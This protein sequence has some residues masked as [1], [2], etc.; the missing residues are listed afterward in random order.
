MFS[1]SL[2]SGE[3]PELERL[4]KEIGARGYRIIGP[5]LE[6][7]VIRLGEL[8]SFD[9]I[10]Y[11]VGDVQKPGYYRIQVNGGRFRSPLDSPKRILY[12]PEL[13][14]FKVT[15]D[16]KLEYPEYR[17][18]ATALFGIKPC[19]LA[20]IRIMDRVQGE[21]GDEY[22]LKMREKLLIVVENCVEPGE[23][24]FCAT[25]GTGPAA[26]TGFD[27]AY[28]RLDDSTILF[29]P[30]SDLGVDLLGELNLEPAT[31]DQIDAF[32]E[33]L[34]KASE[35]ARAGFRLEN[36]PDILELNL[37]SKAYQEIAE[38]CLGCANCNMVCP[39][40]FCFDV[41]DEP[42]LDGS[43]R[44][45]RIW[46]GCHSYSYAQVAGGNFRKD[47]WARYRHW[48]LHK[49]VYWLRQFGSFGCVGCGRCITWCP[50]GID[51][52]EVISKVV[53]EVEERC[54]R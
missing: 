13:T 6:D 41:I 1:G 9:E 4:F 34:L 33:A 38:R 3:L 10:P 18:E 21:L 25:M 47:L 50:A 11:G 7:G 54:K 24:C 48:I 35:K 52:R 49:F 22:F 5:K 17:F 26:S 28:T 14:L 46:D 16:W 44:R 29:Q 39:T 43:A 53:K 20:A 30:G 27:V 51:L 32:R 2:Y 23:N 31:P 37:E 12:P 8:K 42:E 45:I 15:K 19:D 36:L 40:C